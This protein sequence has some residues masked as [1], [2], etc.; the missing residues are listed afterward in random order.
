V[1]KT[2]LVERLLA[3]NPHLYKRDVETIVNIIVAQIAA[4]LARDDRVELRGFGS[5]SLHREARVGRNPANGDKVQ[6]SE[7]RYPYFRTGKTILDRL[8]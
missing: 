6:V 1:T 4:A 8:N 7:K 5:F 3:H 2:E